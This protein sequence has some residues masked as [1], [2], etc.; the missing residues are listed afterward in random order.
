M[1]GVDGPTARSYF[2]SLKVSL[3]N[4]K[5]NRPLALIITTLA[6]AEGIYNTPYT[7]ALATVGGSGSP[8]WSVVSGSL[9]PGVAIQGSALTGT[10]TTAGDFIFTLR[11]DDAGNSA[12]VPPIP[13]EHDVQVV[14]L[15]INKAAQTISGVF[16]GLPASM[17]YGSRFTMSKR[18]HQRGPADLAQFQQSGMHR[19]ES[20]NHGCRAGHLHHHGVA[21]REHELRCRICQLAHRYRRQGKPEDFVFSP[22]PQSSVPLSR[23]V[24]VPPRLFRSLSPVRKAV[25][26]QA[27]R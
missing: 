11:A 7:Q 15:H 16:D 23:S 27:I 5:A 20:H 6:L 1:V 25:R 26:L 9:P 12:Q 21:R 24:A 17:A 3:G 2:Q 22:V 13:A 14:T 18:N 4:Q 10:P 8:V 19:I